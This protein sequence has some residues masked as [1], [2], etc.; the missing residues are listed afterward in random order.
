MNYRNAYV[1][2]TTYAAN[3][4][5]LSMALLIS[6][7]RAITAETAPLQVRHSGPSL[8]LPARLDRRVFKAQQAPLGRRDFRGFEASWDRLAPRVRLAL[9][10]P[11]D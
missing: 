4:A 6:L 7:C 9:Q 11:R 3:D 2:A 5:A 1:A 8:L 10:A